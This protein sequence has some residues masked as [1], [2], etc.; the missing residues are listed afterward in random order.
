MTSFTYTEVHR[1]YVIIITTTLLQFLMQSLASSSMFRIL[2]Q[3]QRITRSVIVSRFFFSTKDPHWR[4]FN[5]SVEGCSAP[6]WVQS[7]YLTTIDPFML[8]LDLGKSWD[9]QKNISWLSFETTPNPGTGASV[10]QAM[11]SGAMFHGS[12]SSPSVWTY[13]G[14]I[15]RGN[16]TFLDSVSP[17]AFYDQSNVYPLWSFSNDTQT[18]NQFD[19]GTLTTPSYGS[20]TES[21]DQ[22]LA[23][24]LHG[25]TDNGTSIGAKYSGDVQTLLDGMIVIDMVRRSSNNISTAGM[26]DPQPRLGGSLEYV[27]GLGSSGVLVSL[28]GKVFDGSKTITSQSQGRLLS[29]DNV[30]VFDLASYSP[31]NSNGTWFSQATSGDIPPARIDACT[32]LASS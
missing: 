20:S 19:I 11:V 30:D 21:P 13:G 32:V 17:Y 31:S 8:Q 26:K 1:R 28:G 6:R 16:E 4:S 24:Y 3:D 22:G 12:Y 9:W 29:F 23:F 5:A 25:R 18:W 2:T 7:A 10:K 15:F 27:P 14:T